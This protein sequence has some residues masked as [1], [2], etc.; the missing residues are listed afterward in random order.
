MKT[1]MKRQKDIEYIREG[2]YIAE[3]EIEL[4]DDGT[5][6]A[7]YISMEDA[8]KLDDVRVAL[9]RGDMKA[10]S[11]HAKVFSLVPLAG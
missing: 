9:K 4:L 2:R 8:E 10:A 11:R 5:G 7:P 3:V 6:W 1:Q